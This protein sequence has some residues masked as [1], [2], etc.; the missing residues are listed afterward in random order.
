MQFRIEK[1]S[2]NERKIVRPLT[3][4]VYTPT[5]ECQMMLSFVPT[6]Q[7]AKHVS[8][9]ALATTTMATGATDGSGLA[10]D[11]GPAAGAGLVAAPPSQCGT[12]RPMLHP[13]APWRG[14]AANPGAGGGVE[15]CGW[16]RGGVVGVQ[17]VPKGLGGVGLHKRNEQSWTI[18]VAYLF[19]RLPATLQ[20]QFLIPK[21]SPLHRR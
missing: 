13:P 14:V 21:A 5:P 10:E 17:G 1:R 7:K 2:Y 3:D 15:R 8:V 11:A 4:K 9:G 12:L 18:A 6:L 16:G 19:Q 20:W